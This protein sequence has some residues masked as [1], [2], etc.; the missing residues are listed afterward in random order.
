[1][2]T[3][4]SSLVIASYNCRGFN[5]SKLFYI[6]NLLKKCNVLFI[7]EH[8]LLVDLIIVKCLGVA[9]MGVLLFCGIKY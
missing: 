4:N 6:N 9:H 8:W 2:E 5:N 3:V 7:E 1:M